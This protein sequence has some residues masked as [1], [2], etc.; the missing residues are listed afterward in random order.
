MD[1]DYVISALED[2]A[3]NSY[4]AMIAK[5]ASLGYIPET[6]DG[7][8]RFAVTFVKGDL[9]G[10]RG[11]FQSS[12]GYTYTQ[13]VY[14]TPKATDDNTLQNLFCISKYCVSDDLTNV[15]EFLTL[16]E[17]DSEIQNILT[18]GVENTHYQLEKYVDKNDNS[19]DQVE[20]GLT[21]AS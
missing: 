4:Y 9:S 20:V 18:F 21:Q 8:Q 7:S 12:T 16:L 13:N 3:L 14:N 17:T 10:Y 6:V 1:D 15:I 2:D 19:Y 11:C 5:Y